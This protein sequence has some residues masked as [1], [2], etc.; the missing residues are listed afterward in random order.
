MTTCPVEPPP[1]FQTLMGFELVRWNPG[2]AEVV[3][4][5][6]EK[7]LNRGG[8]P[9]GGVLA[10]LIDVAGGY[11]G[12]YCATAGRAMSA[13]TISMSVAFVGRTKGPSLRARGRI[14]GGGRRIFF[15]G[16]E[17]EGDDGTLVASGQASYAYRRGFGPPDG[18]LLSDL[19][20][21]RGS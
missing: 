1:G 5:T 3:L 19:L 16:V 18:G 20:V 12:C 6:A 13:Q 10:T 17:I 2:E 8:S 14:I 7:H 9:H 21:S 15:A 11:A 4:R